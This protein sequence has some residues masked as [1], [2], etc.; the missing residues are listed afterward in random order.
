[1]KFTPHLAFDGRCREAF[2]FYERCF[3]GKILTM[4]AYGDTPMADRVPAQHRGRI[5]H[6]T[7]ARE[8]GEVVG[9]DALP[10]QYRTPQGSFVLVNVDEIAKAERIFAALAQGGSIAMPL[11][12]IFWA[13]R[14][15]VVTDRF[16]IAWEI[17]CPRAD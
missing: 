12:E 7:L 1:M 9:A 13:A 5:L 10:E 3:G 11:Q 6:A 8:D 15:G 2:E 16:G 4:L 17:N 14:F